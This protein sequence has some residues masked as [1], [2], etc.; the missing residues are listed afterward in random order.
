MYR[1]GLIGLGFGVGRGY[2]GAGIG[3]PY[4]GGYGGYGLGYGLGYGTDTVI[5]VMVAG[6][7]VS[8]AAYYK[9]SVWVGS[10]GQPI[11]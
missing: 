3:Y 4:M 11:F 9:M 7:T 8:Q 6:T 5:Q 2:M 1:S 10:Q